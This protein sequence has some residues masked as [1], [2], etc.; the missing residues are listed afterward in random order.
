[1][2]PNHVSLAR[3]VSCTLTVCTMP[4][5]P[6][7]YTLS[8]AIS[9]LLGVA[10]ARLR[11]DNQSTST[12]KASLKQNYIH[13]QLSRGWGNTYVGKQLGEVTGISPSASVDEHGEDHVPPPQ[14]KQS[15]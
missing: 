15:I 10:K 1:M 9:Q 7:F 14:R 8:L 5:Q 11:T 12:P 13:F 4:S 2:A 3:G 6:S